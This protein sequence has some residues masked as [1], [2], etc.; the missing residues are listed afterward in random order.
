MSFPQGI[1]SLI[2]ENGVRLSGGQKQRLSLA[3]SLLCSKKL[4]L[5]DDIFSSLDHTTEKN[6]I[7]SLISL[8]I[9]MVIVSHRSSVLDYCHKVFELKNQSLKLI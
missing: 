9:T 1:H 6:L 5:L 3:R 7:A 2:G 8:N 4:Y